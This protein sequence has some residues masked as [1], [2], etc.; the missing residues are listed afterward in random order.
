MGPYDYKGDERFYAEKSIIGGMKVL[1]IKIRYLNKVIK[2]VHPK[3]EIRERYKLY[4]A[5]YNGGQGHVKKALLAAVKKG[6]EAPTWESLIEGKPNSSIFG[7][8]LP[9]RWVS[10]KNT[11]RS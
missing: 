7:S 4:M 8:V 5:V 1:N 6:I 3:M 9:K 11:M 10:V 2:L